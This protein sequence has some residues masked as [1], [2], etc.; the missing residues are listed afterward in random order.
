M[1][2]EGRQAEVWTGVATTGP[3]PAVVAALASGS[4][5]QEN[6]IMVGLAGCL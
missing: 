1:Q 6:P 3:V 4:V 2:S 5:A